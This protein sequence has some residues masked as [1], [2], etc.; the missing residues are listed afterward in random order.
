[1]DV[2]APRLGETWETELYDARAAGRRV[3]ARS[4]RTGF[5]SLSRTSL[6]AGISRIPDCRSIHSSRRE[7]RNRHR[8]DEHQRQCA[9]CETNMPK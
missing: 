5:F 9:E 8:E 1:M 3:I 7:R 4:D 2:G 6:G